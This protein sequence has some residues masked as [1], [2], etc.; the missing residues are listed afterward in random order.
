LKKLKIKKPAINFYDTALISGCIL[1][2]AGV[3]L[4]YMPAAL[5]AAGLFLI[6]GAILLYKPKK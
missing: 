6:A 1:I 2:C 3:W 5:I 4:I